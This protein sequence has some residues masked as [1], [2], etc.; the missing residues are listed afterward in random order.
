MTRSPGAVAHGA[1]ELSLPECYVVPGGRFR[2]LYYWDTYFT[3]LGLARSHRQDLIESMIVNFG[4]LIDRFGH[5]PNGSRS[6]YVSRSHPPF[7][8]LMTELSRNDSVQARGRRLRWMRQEH[9]FW[10][11][12]ADNLAPG[13]AVRRVVRFSDGALLNRYWDDLDGPR[14]E[15]W[16]EDVQLAASAPERNANDLWRDIRAAAESGWDFS[17]RWFADGGDLATIRTTRLIAVDLNALLYGLESTIAT[18][19][20]SLGDGALANEYQTYAQQRAQAIERHLWNDRDGFYADFDLDTG[21]T[22]DRLTAATAFP[23]FVGV[24]SPERA[25]KVIDALG[26]LLRPGGLATT[27]SD[28]GQQWDAPNGWAP[29]QWVAVQALRRHGG[30]HLADA[31]ADRWLTMVE[32]HFLRTGD[33]LEKYDVE[34]CAAGVGGQYDTQI[35]FGWTNGIVLELLA[36]R[37]GESLRDFDLAGNFAE[38]D[39]RPFSS[40]DLA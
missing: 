21:T 34:R 6:Y 31:I 7:F 28:S 39:D 35:G 5:I 14:D 17:S 23:L 8:Y 12:G 20:R 9:R 22:A 16:L 33:L 15:S 11:A 26:L 30:R 19:A 40:I 3:M 36:S 29:L 4:S 10:M 25:Q 13:D 32:G 37:D 2:E 24:A 27:L 38:K 1:S 18:E